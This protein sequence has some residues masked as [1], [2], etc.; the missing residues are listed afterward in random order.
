MFCK[1]I[2]QLPV[3]KHFGIQT[4]SK[5]GGALPKDLMSCIVAVM[6]ANDLALLADSTGVLVV[7]LGMVDA[8]APNMSFSFIQQRR[9][10]RWW[11]DP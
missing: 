10:S 4:I 9:K 8:V 3:N 6:H 7:L 5:L 11:G 2:L 1:A